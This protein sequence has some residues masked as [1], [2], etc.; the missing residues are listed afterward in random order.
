MS[1]TIGLIGCGSM[2]TALVRGIVSAR[3][4]RPSQI[5]VWDVRAAQRNRLVRQLKVR[6]A[7][8]AREAAGA[9]LLLLAVKPQQMEGLLAEI[10]PAVGRRSLVVSVAAGIRTDW[11]ARRL[12][13]GIR[14]VRV[15]PNTP[16]LVG[17]GMSVLSGGRSAKPVDLKRVER[18]LA[19][20]G[21]VLRLPE[22]R[23]DA[24]TALSGSGPA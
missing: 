16:A 2:G 18:L 22:R 23:M 10:R 14:V 3:L 20:V 1:G 6:A 5:R 11:I 7:R 13:G 17:A 15:M 24:V 21:E 8:T 12:G 19:C 4:V 9:D